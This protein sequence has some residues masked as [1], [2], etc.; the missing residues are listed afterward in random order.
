MERFSPRCL[1]LDLEVGV[2]DRRIRAFAALRPDTGGRLVFQGGNLEK[3]LAELDAL[4]DGAAFLLGHNLIRF[5]LP[6]LAAV[7]P[8]LRLLHRPAVDTLWLNPLAFPRNPYHHLVK[9]YQDGRFKR[10]HLNDP[11]LDARLALDLFRDQRHALARVAQESPDLIAAWHWLTTGDEDTS[12]FNAFF[13]SLRGALRPSGAQAREAIRRRLT[14]IVCRTQERAILAGFGFGSTGQEPDRGPDSREQERSGSDESQ[15]GGAPGEG[16]ADPSGRVSVE[17]RSDRREDGAPVSPIDSNLGGWALAY[18]LAWLSVSGG[19]SVMPPWVRHAFPQAGRIVRALRDTACADPGCG[20]CRERHD[21]RKELGRW[22]SF[23]DFRPEPSDPDTGQPM[24]RT[25]VEAAMAGKHVLGILPTGTGKSLCYQIPALSR[26]DKTGALTVVISPLVALMADQVAGLEA[27]GI[28][29]C[30]AVNGLLSMPE[31]ADALD[32]VRLGDAGIL[33]ISPEQLRNRSL[34]RVLDQ[35]EIGAWV[36]DEAHCLS[37]WGH[38]FRP[39]Y[40]YVGR[41]IREKA[42]DEPI[43][44]VLCL[45][46]TAKPDVVVDVTSHFRDELGIELTV[47]DGG[48][49]RTNLEFVVVPTTGGEKLAHL[50]QIL[51]S[52]LPPDMPGGAIVYCATRRQAEEVAEFLQEKDVSADYF[53]AGLPPESRKS[54]QQRFIGGELR[55][56]AATNAFGMGIDKPNVRLVVHADIPGSLENYLQEAGRA[57]RDREVAR[58]VLLYTQDDVE[59]QFGMSARSRLNRREIHG[60]LRA[61]RN[62]DR[63]KRLGGEVVATAGEI[64][65]EDDENAFE[66]DSATDDTR[67]RTAI[68]W[69]E[70]SVLLT[71]EENRTQVFPSSLRVG[72]AEEARARLERKDMTDR[73]RGQLLSIAEMLIDAD[74][75]EG[76]ST[77]ELIGV[78]GL[79][80]EGVRGALYDLE[81]LGIA[82]NDTALTA[83]VHVGVDRHSRKRLEEADSLEVALI[84][85]LRTAAPDLG[86][87]D[88]SLLHLRVASQAL[89]DAGEAD[90]LP[91]R[92]WRILRSISF[93]GRGEGGGGGS[94]RVRK[95]DAET[96]QVTLQRTWSAL[97]ETASRRREGAHRLLEHLLAC[98][99]PGSRGTDLLAETTLGRLLEALEADLVLKSRV[100]H[101][102]KLMDRA[103]LWLHEQEVIRLH[104]GLAVFRPAMTIKLEQEV[105]RRGFAA[106]DFEPLKLHYQGQVTQIHVMVEYARRGLEA[107]ADALHLAMDYFSLKQEAFL[108]RWL[109]DREKEIERQTTPESWRA[110][111][112]SLSN[113]AQQRIVADDR[114]QTN[115]LVLAG[116]GSGKTRVLVHRIAF[117]VRARR[118]PPRGILA[119]VYN[120]HAAVE[121]RRRLADL[122]GD[123]A[124]GVTVLTCH[125]LAMRLA[126]AS[127]SGRAERPDGE[128][129]QEVMRQAVALLRGEGLPPEEA[130]EQ[131]EWLLAGFRWILVDEYQDIDADQYELISALAGRTLDDGDRKLT[132]FAVGDDDQNIYAFNGA[133]VEFIRRFEADYGPKPAFLTANYRST[134]HIIAAANALIEPARDRMKTGHPIRIDRARAKEPPGGD[135]RELDP[136]ARGRVQILP[137]QSDPIEQARAAMTELL[138]LAGLAP[139]WDWSNCAVIAREWKYLEPV[140]AFCELHRIP[141]QMGNEEIPRFWRLRETQ[142]LVEWLRGRASRLVAGADLRGWLDARPQ[143]PWI[144]LLR[145]AVDEHALETGGGAEVPVA[146]FIEWLAEWGRDVRRRQRGLLLSTAHRAKGLEFDHVAVLDGGWDRVGEDEDPDA[147]RRL[148]YVAMTRARRTLAL[149]RLSCSPPSSDAGRPD[150]VRE[151]PHPAYL[152]Q[153]HPLQQAIADSHS[154]LR[155]QSGTTRRESPERVAGFSRRYRRPGLDEINL[156]LAGRHRI[157]HPVHRAIAALAPGDPLDVRMDAR[158]RWELLDRSGTV[159]GRM[160]R[161]FEPPAGM[162][163]VSVAVHA[164]VTWSRDASEPEFQVGLKCDRW[165]VVV[166]ELIFEPDG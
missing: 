125:G 64:L 52:D 20:W 102:E 157:G 158:K 122:I 72:T 77:D 124:R 166:P 91:E 9:H 96:A 53:H 141:V 67:V 86:K 161:A 59:R 150:F 139:G 155:R 121:I 37:K 8:D 73:Y 71:R 46:A 142:A 70:E 50:H 100:K 138:R 44:P 140:R 22:F 137:Q 32:R 19:N 111:V 28:V 55:V 160:A 84:E 153:R 42:G 119:L 90:P 92:L 146:H 24:Q 1:S 107:M 144:E 81:P 35:R 45:T 40:R 109:P 143:G 41:F 152:A 21:A 85:H 6:H 123:D 93:D 103:L 39:D 30:V 113:P 133:S 164:V 54:V 154:V 135:W 151:P 16:G 163:C 136:V 11:E 3:A 25:I 69:L 57:G 7:Q 2:R 104:K 78:T 74:P 12:G 49:Q 15:R 79:S 51:E 17:V 128:A 118:E 116:P 47:F 58:C 115:V 10:G 134:R 38:D 87:G 112:E 127:F 99:P 132:L 106:T 95:S 66:R 162:R 43:P 101:P 156:G 13:A 145:E 89:R 105:P 88:M 4:A 120:R 65:G 61:L 14:G 60:V 5:D 108:N 82:S 68:A 23:E 117:L 130:D 159:V 126:G 110:I 29:A 94:L 31:R 34:R 48:A 75:N 18:A 131:R 129:F 27:R 114:E 98:L 76:I 63:K 83:F 36:L 165:E 149:A 148:Y 56:I 33:I 80:P 26:Y 62:L 97:E 147:P